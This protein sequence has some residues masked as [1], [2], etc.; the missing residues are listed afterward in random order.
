MGES[1][2]GKAQAAELNRMVNEFKLS[3]TSFTR[4][5][6]PINTPS[7]QSGFSVPAG[8]ATGA[9]N[10]IR[11]LADTESKGSKQ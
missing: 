1:L 5:A 6:A 8:K 3:K 10:R 7:K 9:G 4:Q 2:K 11:K